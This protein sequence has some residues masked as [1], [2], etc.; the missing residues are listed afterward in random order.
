MG[1]HIIASY[2]NNGVGRNRSRS[3]SRSRDDGSGYR[4]SGRGKYDSRYDNSRGRG[5]YVPRGGFSSR[6]G[7][8]S[9]GPG[10]TKSK[11]LCF[12]FAK[13][14]C[15]R[16]ESCRF[17]HDETALAAAT[18]TGY[19]DGPG[20]G[21]APCYDY[22]KGKCTRGDTCRF[23]HV[24]V[25]LKKTPQTPSMSR[26][27]S[28]IAST[29]M[30]A[31]STH[32]P[33]GVCFEF[34][35]NRCTRGDT[36][37]YLHE[38]PSASS[39]DRESS[40][41]SSWDARDRGRDRD[42]DRD[43]AGSGNTPRDSIGNTAS[44]VGDRLNDRPYSSYSSSGDGFSKKPYTANS[45]GNSYSRDR[46]SGGRGR[47]TVPSWVGN[48]SGDRN[49]GANTPEM[50]RSSYDGR[51]GG[52]YD[53]GSERGR[54]RSNYHDDYRSSSNNNAY[55]GAGAFSESNYP[56]KPREESSSHV[57]PAPAAAPTSSKT[58]PAPWVPVIEK[59]TGDTYYWN[60]KTGETT[61]DLPTAS[62]TSSDSPAR[63]DNEASSSSRYPGK[64]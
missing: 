50:T 17:S 8:N 21:P 60:R 18:T 47:S 63:R 61:W 52:Y 43:Y 24:D 7:Y 1:V 51:G 28:D 5:G 10:F 20:G 39:R 30:H 6:G 38:I 46:D 9:S 36:C 49:S 13:G 42:R 26:E 64:F 22:P 16:G 58:V 62:A 54:E 35:R 4:G 57:P 32:V 53:E 14:T 45:T 59:E 11:G 44:R 25:D 56:S 48:K 12:D 2:T 31:S 34:A 55:P 27:T 41:P 40:A 15:T 37:R 3:R 29:P 23:A 19:A 33:L